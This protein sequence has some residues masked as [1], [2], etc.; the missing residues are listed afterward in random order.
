MTQGRSGR[1]GTASI[2]LLVILAITAAWWALALWPAGAAPPEWLERTRAACF[3]AA[4][5]GL[6]DL[7]GWILLVGEP[8]GMLGVLVAVWPDALRHD[9]RRMQAR[10]SWRL[11]GFSLVVMG[12]AGLATLGWR[13]ARASAFG[14]APR[15]V[16]SGTA[17]RVDVDISALALTDQH[18]SRVSFG[19]FRGRPVLLTFAFGHCGTVCPMVVHDVLAA[20][21]AVNRAEVPLVVMTLDPWRDVPDRLSSLAEQWGVGAGDRVLSGS[22]TEV[23]RALDSL[24]IGRQRDEMTGNI[25]HGGTVMLVDARGHI[26]WRLDGGWSQLRGLLAEQPST[27]P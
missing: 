4:H 16:A 26:T 8:M 21:T 17:T 7:G 13:V 19:D 2:A 3:G 9:L 24:G 22:V 18:G 1:P 6:P 27:V 14:V 5:N 20:R 12:V 25:E 11:A 10:R 15:T 23:E